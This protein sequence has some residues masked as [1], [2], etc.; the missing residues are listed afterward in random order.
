MP[1]ALSLSRSELP[2]EIATAIEALCV[3]ER[4]NGGT[5]FGSERGR[6]RR[7]E[8]A[9]EARSALTAAIL[10]RL[11]E[12]EARREEWEQ[13]AKVEASQRRHALA[14]VERLEKALRLVDESGRKQSGGDEIGAVLLYSQV[15]REVRSALSE[16][17][18]QGEQ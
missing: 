16:A 2:E 8:E 9:T 13:A 5:F 15:W 11:G 4:R 1:D 3:V 18:L 10:S 6:N 12:A 17:P 7:E 14:R